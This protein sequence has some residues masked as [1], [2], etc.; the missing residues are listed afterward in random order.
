MIGVRLSTECLIDQAEDNNVNIHRTISDWLEPTP[1]ISGLS[2]RCVS[3][4]KVSEASQLPTC[5]KLNTVY[6]YC[7]RLILS[8]QHL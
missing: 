4:I 5:T 8:Q 6:S 1:A 2:K 3:I 7:F